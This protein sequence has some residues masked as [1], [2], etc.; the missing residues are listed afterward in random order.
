MSEKSVKKWMGITEYGRHRGITHVAVKD[1][2]KKGLLT[3]ENQAI[4]IRKNGKGTGK[5]VSINTA[6]ADAIWNK[7]VIQQHSNAHSENPS[8]TYHG[9]KEMA[10][11]QA[12]EIK[13][14][15]YHQSR[16]IKEAFAAKLAQID[17]EKKSGNLCKT[18]DV[19][20]A[21]KDMARVTRDYLLNMPSKLA[22]LLAAENDINEIHKL[23]EDEIHNALTNLSNGSIF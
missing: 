8:S 3:E 7:E 15:S 12:S 18:E 22:P 6:K 2:I 11:G 9:P 20:R 13:G 19:A 4:K 17:Y 5:R 21:A 1:Q 16:S 23:L 10:P 14:P